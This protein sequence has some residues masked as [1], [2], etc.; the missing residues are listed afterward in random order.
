MI[1]ES[2]Q[3]MRQDKLDR[4][5]RRHTGALCMMPADVAAFSDALRAA[6]PAI[7]FVS[8]DYWKHFVDRKRFEADCREFER[9][10]KLNLPR[11]HVR[12][13]M[14]DPTGEALHYW[15]SLADPAETR[16]LAWIE[17][18]RW[19]PVWRPA[20]QFGK[21]FIENTPRLWFDFYRSEFIVRPF[22]HRYETEPRPSHTRQNI[23]LQGHAFEI[24]WNPSEPEAEAFAKKVYNILRKLTACEFKVFEPES[25]RAFDPGTW[26]MPTGCLA[27]RHALA[28]SLKRRHN[29][30]GCGWRNLLKSAE[31]RFRPGDVMTKAEV[32]RWRAD[33][34]ALFEETLRLQKEAV[35]HFRDLPRGNY[36]FQY[37]G[38]RLVS[39]RL[40]KPKGTGPA[41]PTDSGSRVALELRVRRRHGRAEWGNRSSNRPHS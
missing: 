18:R 28:W 40:F 30:F 16:F 2:F 34:D 37:D 4:P 5:A 1:P 29:Y 3:E 6:F 27:G 13:H 22:G 39:A 33:R 32:R 8:R 23:T 25:R 17:P 19:Q 15:G 21:R 24:R 31:Y 20:D 26:R 41:A 14:R 11:D 36:E 10:W 7:R 38:D 35:E 12:R 9:R